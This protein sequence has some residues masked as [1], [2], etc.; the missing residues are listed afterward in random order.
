MA[1]AFSTRSYSPFTSVVSMLQMIRPGS[2]LLPLTSSCGPTVSEPAP[3][4]QPVK[5]CSDQ[6]GSPNSF[7]Q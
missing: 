6:S 2:G 1:P 3:S 7:V 4:C 5:P